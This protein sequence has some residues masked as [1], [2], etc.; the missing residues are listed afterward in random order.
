MKLSCTGY[1]PIY[2]YHDDGDDKDDL[3]RSTPHRGPY[4]ASSM[5]ERT[6]SCLLTG[7]KLGCPQG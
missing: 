3:T 7:E 4:R 6:T 2:K 1:V 5:H